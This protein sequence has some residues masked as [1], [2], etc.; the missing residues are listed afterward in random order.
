MFA[1]RHLLSPWDGGV[2]GAAGAM[3]VVFMRVSPTHVPIDIP[4]RNEAPCG[5]ADLG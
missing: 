5:V 2:D 4:F 1:V 3:E